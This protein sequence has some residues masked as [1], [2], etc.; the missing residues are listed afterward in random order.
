MILLHKHNRLNGYK[1]FRGPR[2]PQ[3][4]QRKLTSVGV[5]VPFPRLLGSVEPGP[6]GVAG[7]PRTAAA[8][9]TS[10]TRRMFPIIPF[11]SPESSRILQKNPES[12]GNLR[13]H[14]DR[15]LHMAGGGTDAQK[16]ST[17]VRAPRAFVRRAAALRSV[18]VGDR[19]V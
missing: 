14:L 5:A 18:I 12:S 15:G 10:R 3:E 2:G 17:R 8:V 9:R 11:G 16:T 7:S 13:S 19:V 6:L 4:P 1:L